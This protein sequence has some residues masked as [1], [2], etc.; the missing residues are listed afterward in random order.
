MISWFAIYGNAFKLQFI[1]H[2]MILE[3]SR[4]GP[5]LQFSEGKL[6]FPW[7]LTFSIEFIHSALGENACFILKEKSWNKYEQNLAISYL[8]L[9]IICWQFEPLLR[10]YLNYSLNSFPIPIL[11]EINSN[12]VMHTL[13]LLILKTVQWNKY[14]HPNLKWEKWDREEIQT[15]IFPI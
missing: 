9:W 5:L 10:N 14:C 6:D 11:Y 7:K 4:L 3:S 1:L 15:Y 12:Q 8:Q 13:F 2:I